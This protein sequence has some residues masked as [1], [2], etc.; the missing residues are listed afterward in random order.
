MLLSCGGFGLFLCVLHRREERMLKQ[1]LSVL[2]DMQCMLR[3]QLTP[4]P[5]L[6]HDVGL[7][8]RGWVKQIFLQLGQELESCVCTDVSSAMER[9]LSCVVL[10]SGKAK[11]NLLILGNSLGRFDLEGQ[12]QGL[13]SLRQ[14]CSQ[15]I[16]DLLC[17]QQ[18]RL[19]SYQTLGLCAGAALVII[20]L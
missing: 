3:Y 13:E 18:Q 11:E 6:C 9:V 12:L 8:S 15:D 5:D 7:R 10:P 4:L 17:D 20:F 1:L 2:E 16:S 14:K 19:R